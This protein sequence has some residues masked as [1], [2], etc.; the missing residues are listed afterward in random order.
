[1][2]QL[3]TEFK[4]MQ[5][6]EENKQRLSTICDKIHQDSDEM[7]KRYVEFLKTI[8]VRDTNNEAR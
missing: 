7:R 2:Q 6:P 3:V 5:I 8:K 1:M 4:K